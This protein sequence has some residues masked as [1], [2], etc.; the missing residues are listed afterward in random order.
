[1]S[2]QH[3]LINKWLSEELPPTL[4]NKKNITEFIVSLIPKS[5]E[6]LIFK[7]MLIFNEPL[8][9]Q[10]LFVKEDSDCSDINYYTYSKHNIKFVYSIDFMG[11]RQ[12]GD[13]YCYAL[14]ISKN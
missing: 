10:N 12:C 11:I 4:T 5:S 8:N 6:M 3:E 9:A 1:M 14:E 2:N 13:K 7:S